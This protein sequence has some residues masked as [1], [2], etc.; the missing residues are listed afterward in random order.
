MFLLRIGIDKRSERPQNLF[1]SRTKRNQRNIDEHLSK[2][3]FFRL[4]K[5]KKDATTTTPTKPDAIETNDGQETY[6]PN[7]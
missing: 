2:K 5:I 4:T 1:N 6:C 7:S 3:T